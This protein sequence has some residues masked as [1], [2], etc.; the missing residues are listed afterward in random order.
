MKK[1]V[2]FVAALFVGATT[3]A[4]DGLTS[5]KGEAFLPEAG[6]FALGFDGSPFINYV[7]NMANGNASNSLSFNNMYNTVYGKM[8]KDENTA[9]RGMVRLGMSSESS[10]ALSGGSNGDSLT[11]TTTNSNGFTFIV[12]AGLEK[13]RGAG[14]LQGVYGAQVMFGMIGAANT[15]YEYD[16]VI[17][18]TN[19]IGNRALENN[20][21][22]TLNIGL[23][24][25]AGVEYFILP[26]FSLAAEVTWGLG[27]MS[28]G[29]GENISEGW[30]G[31]AVESTTSKTGGSSSF[32]LDNSAGANFKVLFHF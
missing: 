29:E 24:G 18:A 14:R 26:K 1:K 12:G 32:S 9:Y 27:F 5:K 23:E 28:T 30:N 7:G 2:L 20:G 17:D 31:T 4:Q 16:E 6:D 10:D 3:F 15:S 21:G 8:F 25:F 13:R 19:P 11:T 22:S